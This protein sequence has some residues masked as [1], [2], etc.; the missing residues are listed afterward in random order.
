MMPTRISISTRCWTWLLAA[1]FIFAPLPMPVFAQDVVPEPETAPPPPEEMAA[2]PD[3]AVPGPDTM[4]QPPE[5]DGPAPDVVEA[6]PAPVAQE[7]LT[8]AEA[9]RARIQRL[10]AERTA[11]AAAAAPAFAAEE[12]PPG[13]PKR[14]STRPDDEQVYSLNLKDASIDVLLDR[15]SELTGRT[16]IKAPGV[17]A[18]FTFKAQS[19]LT[20]AEMI[21]AMDSLLSMSK[22]SLVPLGT[23]FYRVVP[24]DTAPTEG[25]TIQKAPPEGGHPE[26]DVLVS[27]LI[28]LKYLDME[29]AKVIVVQ[30]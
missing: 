14:P 4:D 2:A 17:N 9:A 3:T 10:R 19:K 22:F 5:Q 29:D 16:M 21:Q 30:A 13:S 15:Y 20:R 24:M 12:P 18:T 7:E 6:V 8:P 25:L 11:A 1:A 23:R 27:Q 28:G 26:S